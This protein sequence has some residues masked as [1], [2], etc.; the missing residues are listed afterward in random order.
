MKGQCKGWRRTGAFQLGG[1]GRWEQCKNLATMR[2]TFIQEGKRSTML[3]CEKCK[4]EAEGNAAIK[5][6][7]AK[8]L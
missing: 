6:K 5:V 7:G 8:P 4:K 3:A 1:T 2:L